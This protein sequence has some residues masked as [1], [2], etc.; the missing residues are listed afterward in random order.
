MPYR[1]TLLYAFVLLSLAQNDSFAQAQNLKTLS[2]ERLTTDQGLSQGHVICMLQDRRGFMWFGTEDGLN[3]YDGISFKHF[4]NGN[5]KN[6]LP[7]NY[8]ESLY[9]DMHGVLWVGTKSGLAKFDRISETFTSYRSIAHDSTSLPANYITSI[10]DDQTGAYL[11]V[12]TYGGGLA[13][14]NK[15]TQKF[16]SFR[17]NVGKQG[18][19][20]SDIIWRLAKDTSGEIW[21]GTFKGGF[22]HYMAQSNTF[23]QFVPDSSTASDLYIESLCADHNGIIWLGT[24]QGLWKFEYSQAKRTGTFTHYG[25]DP[26]NPRALQRPIVNAV[27]EDRDGRIWVGTSS[28]L[29]LFNKEHGDFTCFKSSPVDAYS[30]VNDD[31]TSL[32]EDRAGTIWVGTM[33]GISYCNPQPPKFITYRAESGRVNSLSDNVIWSFAAMKDGRVWVGTESGLC[34]LESKPLSGVNT[35]STFRKNDKLPNQLR[36]NVITALRTSRDGTLWI[37]TNEGGLQAMK[38][39]DV[40]GVGSFTSYPSNDEDTTSLSSNLISCIIEDKRGKIWVGTANGVSRLDRIDGTGKAVF[41][42]FVSN[43]L[44]FQASLAN[45]NVSALCEDRQGMIWVGTENGLTRI[46]PSSGAM[47]SYHIIDGD[48][49]D[50]LSQL[51]ADDDAIQVMCESKNGTMWIGTHRGLFRFDRTSGKFTRMNKSETGFSSARTQA[52]SVILGILEDNAG[53]LWLSTNTGLS[54]YTPSTNS[55]RR[56]DT[57][58]GLQGREFVTGAAYKDKNGVMY[59]GGVNGFSA[60]H[61]DSLRSNAAVPPVVF[62]EFKRFG[63]PI[64]LDTAISEKRHIILSHKDN[65]F[66]I[67]FAA[68]SFTYATRNQYRYKLEGFDEHWYSAN[69]TTEARYANLDPGVYN[70]RVQASN[71]DEVWNEAGTT[72]TIEIPPP[73]YATWW[74]RA[75]V[76]ALIG[77]IALV[78]VINRTGRG[79]A[80]TASTATLIVLLLSELLGDFAIAPLVKLIFPEGNRPNEL[81]GLVIK[82]ALIYFAL[83][84]LEG[85]L[86]SFL[87]QRAK[88][89][90]ASHTPSGNT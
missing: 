20:Q 75:C 34:R 60:F 47:K 32:Y 42:R 65:T 30:L 9:E 58:D 8:V 69:A 29:H 90:Q 82:L 73:F 3:R 11:W 81:I 43:P 64:P 85:R 40:Y 31:I 53:N 25:A 24:S 6:S 87:A 56:Y 27:L 12:G 76:F 38:R 22:S 59:F 70:F 1:A 7:S 19:L 78:T 21:A 28:G 44:D 55:F 15:A 13:R 14:L 23:Q 66:E 83:V 67:Q 51:G 63:I 49:T 48:T 4:T 17:R 54:R 77:G 79:N 84:P 16:T 88:E 41:T 57:R 61:P 46:E 36:D 35:F 74:F 86:H 10:V 2:F 80:A 68:L 71:Y 39:T 5:N 18:A 50:N 52:L 37:G 33:D 45:P 62:T 26:S 89:Q 72:L